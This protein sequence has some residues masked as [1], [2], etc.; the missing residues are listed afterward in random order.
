MRRRR[1]RVVTLVYPGLHLFEFG[2]VFEIFG[3]DRLG[4]GNDWYDFR[5]CAVD[6]GSIRTQ[7]GLILRS[8]P[9]L[10]LVASA[11][12][13]LIPGWPVDNR[14]S[15]ELKSALLRAH[16]RGARLASICSGAFALAQ[17]GLLDGGTATTHWVHADL[18]ARRFPEVALKRDVLYVHHDRI[19]TSAGSAAG[20]DMML[21]LIRHDM[22]SEV[23]NR[24]ARR[25]VI[26]PHRSGGQ[27]Q[28]IERPSPDSGDD[29]LQDTVEWIRAHAHERMPV[30]AMARRAGTSTRTFFR[31]FKLQLGI[32]PQEFLSQE[33]I[34]SARLLLEQ[35][36]LTLDQVA[37]RCG[38]ESVDTFR[39]HFR[40]IVGQPPSEYRKRFSLE[41]SR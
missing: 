12:T 16:R 27:A 15:A 37:E 6:E 34:A 11:D 40:R 26:P 29:R 9:D 41:V 36:R 7:A 28:F 33:R 1:H 39:H 38:F 23:C 24:M 2:C 21:D 25:L 8:E 22:G 17:T 31:K 10:R 4:A 14:I 18:F 19:V 35:D 32:T 20:I 3:A 5:T 13:V 30:A